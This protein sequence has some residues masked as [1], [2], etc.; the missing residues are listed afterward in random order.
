MD[1]SKPD[2]QHV[3]IRYNNMHGHGL[4][5][6]KI[7]LHTDADL[8]GMYETLQGKNLIQLWTYTQNKSISV[9]NSSLSADSQEVDQIYEQLR[10][11]HKENMFD[12]EQLR[13]WAYLTKMGEHASLN[14][15]PDKSY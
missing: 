8:H 10:E 6:K 9:G 7:W 13:V 12:E 3:E 4:K 5:G 11:K 1:I 15:P 2:L 14:E